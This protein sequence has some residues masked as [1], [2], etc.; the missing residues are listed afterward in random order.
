MRFAQPLL[1][2]TLLESVHTLKLKEHAL[3]LNAPPLPQRTRSSGC[4]CEV[5]KFKFQETTLY[6]NTIVQ[7][8]IP[9][10]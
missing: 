10:P 1:D 8:C 7:H 6:N 3:K 5:F 4:H 9:H 2:A